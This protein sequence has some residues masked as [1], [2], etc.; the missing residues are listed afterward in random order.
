MGRAWVFKNKEAFLANR[1]LYSL[2]GRSVL[3]SDEDYKAVRELVSAA[4]A[5]TG[6]EVSGTIQDYSKALE[7][8]EEARGR[9]LRTGQGSEFTLDLSKQPYSMRQQTKPEWLRDDVSKVLVSWTWKKVSEEHSRVPGTTVSLFL[10]DPV[11]APFTTVEG[12]RLRS[13]LQNSAQIYG[14]AR[15]IEDRCFD[16]N[17][18]PLAG[19]HLQSCAYNDDED[20][21]RFRRTDHHL[22]DLWRDDVLLTSVATGRALTADETLSLIPLPLYK[23]FI[24][25]QSKPMTHF[26]EKWKNWLQEVVTMCSQ[27]KRNLTMSELPTSG[28]GSLFNAVMDIRAGKGKDVMRS[29][30]GEGSEP[31]TIQKYFESISPLQRF[32]AVNGRLALSNLTDDEVMSLLPPRAYYQWKEIEAGREGFSIKKIIHGYHSRWQGHAAAGTN[33]ADNSAAQ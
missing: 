6:E 20:S 33:S 13:R 18:L 9:Q 5:N 4:M 7:S 29:R 12:G 22:L 17:A 32:M 25:H 21:A 26:S 16:P 10:D 11:V 3:I 8:L 14:N 24:H 30:Y 19:V 27:T 15:E 31:L 28:Y 2:D 1:V 23:D